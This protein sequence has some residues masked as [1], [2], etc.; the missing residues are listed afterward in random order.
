[1]WTCGLGK[2]TSA[3]IADWAHESTFHHRLWSRFQS[4]VF[5]AWYPVRAYAEGV[6]AGQA[7]VSQD[8]QSQP[9]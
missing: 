9:G 2:T 5:K 7:Y 8:V 4:I 6:F 3:F 1:M